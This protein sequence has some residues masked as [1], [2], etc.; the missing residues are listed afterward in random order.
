MLSNVSSVQYNTISN[1]H[2]FFQSFSLCFHHQHELHFGLVKHT[3]TRPLF[4]KVFQIE[5][6][7]FSVVC[8]ALGPLMSV[9]VPPQQC[10]L[11]LFERFYCQ[12][13]GN[14]AWCLLMINCFKKTCTK[15]CGSWQKPDKSYSKVCF[16]CI[17]KVLL[18]KVT[19]WFACRLRV[20]VASMGWH[21]FFVIC[22]SVCLTWM[23]W[24]VFAGNMFSLG[25][26]CCIE[27]SVNAIVL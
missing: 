13:N 18:S 8:L 3:I 26:P 4:S 21:N 1:R 19:G 11:T 27:L 5:V 16:R 25:Y 24:S 9:K 6:P 12:H 17:W 10:T 2:V 15:P 22:P 7:R 23:H 20:L 14:F